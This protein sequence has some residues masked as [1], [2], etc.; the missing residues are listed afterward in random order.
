MTAEADLATG[1]GLSR[2]TIVALHLIPGVLITVG[3]VAAAPVVASLGFPPL[4]ALLAAIAFILV[5][6]ELGIVLWAGRGQ[7]TGPLGAVPYRRPIRARDW[8]WLLP[9]LIVVAFLGFGVHAVVEPQLIAALFGWLPDWFVRPIDPDRIG[10]FS[11]G[12]WTVTLVAFFML[13]AIVGPIV[14]E[15]YFRGFL[16]PRMQWLGRWAPLVNV[17]LFSLYHFW[18]PWQFV[19]RILGIGPLVYAVQWKRNVFLGIAVH[20]VL[21]AISVIIVAMLVIGRIA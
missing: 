19:A 10:D 1:Q 5:P 4:A 16:L 20:C 2:A 6:V 13:N 15:L 12:A 18:S 8:L 11:A 17:S 21:N 3:F 7:Q 9:A 14:E